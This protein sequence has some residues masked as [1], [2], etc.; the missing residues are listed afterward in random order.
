MTSVDASSPEVAPRLSLISFAV[1]T[2]RLGVGLGL[3]RATLNGVLNL[4]VA[5]R[6]SPKLER[7]HPTQ[8][9]VFVTTFAKSGTNWAMQMCLE[10]A[11]RGTASYQ[12]IHDV[13]AWPEIPNARIPVLD[14]PRPWR[15]S[16]TG[17]RV[18][19]TH[20]AATV[21]P[22][23]AAARYVTVLRDP[24]DV[25]VSAYHFILG[26]LG[27]R[28]KVTLSQ[29]YELCVGPEGLIS[30]W[31]D[32]AASFWSWRTRPNVFVRPF[33]ALLDDHAGPWMTSQS[34]WGWRSLQPSARR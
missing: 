19:K 3:R 29:W 21:V 1:L 16:P 11:H 20:M 14:D 2:A 24:K 31:V 28:G 30:R 9:D 23:D 13:V 32:H 6:R 7:Y 34:S 10:I 5:P 17:M 4:L 27:V 26:V 22:Y 18:I 12:H 8:H 33:H 25:L 15:D